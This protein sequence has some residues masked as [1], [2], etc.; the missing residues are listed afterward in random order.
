MVYHPALLA[1]HFHRPF[2]VIHQFTVPTHQLLPV[3]TRGEKDLVVVNGESS[4]VNL[5][6]QRIPKGDF[7]TLEIIERAFNPGKRVVQPFS[8]VFNS[9]SLTSFTCG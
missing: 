9:S 4:G 3:R 6:H 7:V 8:K 1:K 2:H 5:L